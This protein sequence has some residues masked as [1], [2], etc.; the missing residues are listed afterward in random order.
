MAAPPDA[1][2][3]DALVTEL[4]SAIVEQQYN[5]DEIGVGD[6][7]NEETYRQMCALSKRAHDAARALAGHGGHGRAAT[8]MNVMSMDLDSIVR[9][10]RERRCSVEHIVSHMRHSPDTDIQI[11]AMRALN[12]LC[13][14]GI[15]RRKEIGRADGGAL[16]RFLNDRDGPFSR[17]SWA[18][19]L[20]EEL[21]NGSWADTNKATI[22]RK[23]GIQAIMSVISSPRAY[24]H[25]HHALRL[26][27]NLIADTGVHHQSICNSGMVSLLVDTMAGSWASPVTDSQIGTQNYVLRV[28]NDLIKTPL[29]KAKTDAQKQAVAIMTQ[30]GA[31]QKL[32]MLYRDGEDN[33]G[34]NDVKNYAGALLGQMVR[35]EGNAR[36]VMNLGFAALCNENLRMPF[37]KGSLGAL[38]VLVNLVDQGDAI[39]SELGEAGVVEALVDI[40]RSCP[41]DF[42]ARWAQTVAALCT[43]T[44]NGH[45][46]NV[47]RAVGGGAIELTLPRLSQNSH[48]E[49]IGAATLLADLAKDNPANAEAIALAGA[50]STLATNAVS[51]ATNEN[52]RVAMVK[53]LAELAQCL[54]IAVAA[55]NAAENRGGGENRKRRRKSNIG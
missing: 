7:V 25:Q 32:M 17:V 19:S 51:A 18:F 52:E 11:K 54:T 28:L 45:T 15:E 35:D 42:Q 48:C 55:P 27:Q 36:A 12:N 31:L 44:H 49:R 20:A 23:G 37:H 38:K 22:V 43:L 2:T 53:V 26:L 16:V 34:F 10:V 3:R 5:L 6:R 13:D 8:A 4:T 21:T 24:N 9:E 33:H 41:D 46:A 1:A 47:E 50:V 14:D 39:R 30:K 40:L 29:R